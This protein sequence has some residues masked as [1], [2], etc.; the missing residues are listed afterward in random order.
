[1]SRKT[2]IN[3]NLPPADDLFSTEESREESQLEKVINL[4]PSDISD[5]P[6]HPFKVRMDEDMQNLMES[7][8][9]HGVLV[10]ALVRPT[11]DGGYQ[12]VAGHRR[13]YA[14]EQVGIS[15]I[16]CI[17]RNFT[18]DEATIVMVDS[19]IQSPRNL[20]SEKAFAYK[21]KLEAI[22]RVAGRPVKNNSV[23]VGQNFGKTSREIVAEESPDSNT[24]IQRYICLT[25]LIPE[26]LD[27]VDNSVL[28]EKDKM[29]MAMRPAVELSKLKWEEQTALFRIIQEAVCTPSHDQAIRMRQLSESRKKS[30]GRVDQ[31]ELLAIMQEDKPNQIE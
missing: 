23:P 18:D 26:L 14:S 27:L 7:V 8:S 13:K 5:F 30:G 11:P 17:I 6:N 29:Q 21:M 16:P 12:M 4:K 20:P 22:R 9:Q 10:P 2:T 28:K 15:E 24:Q 31:I 25:D 3:L 19:N 1:M